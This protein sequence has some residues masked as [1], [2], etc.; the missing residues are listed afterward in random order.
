MY[1]TDEEEMDETGK[2][3]LQN[4]D[5]LMAF[6]KGGMRKEMADR[7]APAPPEEAPPEGMEAAPE[8]EPIPGVE[9]EEG[10]PEG[11]AGPEG[12]DLEKLKAM[13]MQMKGA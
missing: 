7:Y 13:L 6:A 10:A 4:L 2:L 1:P 8:G 3:D 9:A 5:E 12:L 11:G